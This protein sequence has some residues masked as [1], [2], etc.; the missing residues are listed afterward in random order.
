MDI[1]LHNTMAR[2]VEIFTP[3][4]KGEVK[5][6]AC[7][8]TVYGYQHIG[9]L[10]TY[11]SED[12]L[13]RMFLY[14]K[15]KI[16][17]VINVTDVGHLTSDSDVG[18][19]KLV[20][21]LK[22]EGL[23][24]TAEAMLKLSDK[25]F[26]E[27]KKD[28]ERLNIISPDVWSKAT[29]HI[30]EMIKLVKKIEKNGYTYSAGGNVYF[31]ISKFK[32]YGKLAKLKLD[33]LQAGSRKDIDTE[34][35]SPLDFVLWFTKSRYKQIMMWDSPWGM[36]WPGWHLEC[37][38][39]SMKYLGEQFD[40][41]CGGKEHIP[42]HHT[43]EIAQSEAA[44]GKKWVNY[45]L[46]TEWLTLKEGKMSKSKGTFFRV[47]QLVDKGYDPLA[48]RYLCLTAHYRTPLT[49]S[50][51]ALDAAQTA[52]NRLKENVI[53]L[54]KDLSSG[55]DRQKFDYY[56]EEFHRAINNDLDT[57]KA[58]SLVWNILKDKELGSKEKFE[59][60]VDYDRVLG[61]NI[62]DMEEEIVEVSKEI[63]DKIKK[64]EKARKEK[65]WKTADKLRDELLAEGIILKDTPV[66][67]KWEK[68]K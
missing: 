15:Y 4:K 39:M 33:E 2:K 49:F 38:A 11:V 18:E 17:H 29:E 35:K 22:R 37:S 20:K 46:H 59:L 68:K 42:V 16:K 24:L 53:A 56:K 62:E 65:D 31:D 6:Y 45:W 43:N 8:P 61:L 9:N 63:M 44:T 30:K 19:D 55:M 41:H 64:R 32:D 25:Y 26:Q 1:K 34:K 57:P 27:F 12:L 40:I 13:K 66:G 67:V 7:G 14:N 36:G 47:S 54:K 58:I 48:Y 5:I 50:W 60:L 3:I 52:F 21:A 23:P 51:D 10:R 28:F